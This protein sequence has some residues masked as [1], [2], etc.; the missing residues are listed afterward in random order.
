MNKSDS[1]KIFAQFLD[2]VQEVPEKIALITDQSQMSYRDISNL[3]RVI[4]IQLSQYNIKKGQTIVLA[5]KR[6]E[7]VFAF[8]IVSS[9]RNFTLVFASDREIKNGGLEFDRIVG[10][11]ESPCFSVASQIIIEPAWFDLMGSIPEWNWDGNE[12]GSCAFVTTTSGS[13]GRPKFVYLSEEAILKDI[14]EIRWDSGSELRSMRHVSTSQ[15]T[16]G[17]SLRTNLRVLLAGG[18]VIA[19]CESLQTAIQMAELWRASNMTT[20]PGAMQATLSQNKSEQYLSNLRKIVL[21]GAYA[22]TELLQKLSEKTPAEVF[23]SYGASE[24]GPLIIDRFD[25]ESPSQAGHMGRIDRSDID[26]VFC[27]EDGKIDR[28][29]S[30]GELVIKFKEPYERKYLG[31]SVEETYLQKDLFRSGDILRR[32]GDVF[33][34]LGR[35]KN[36]LNQNGNKYSLESIEQTLKSVF[37]NTEFVALAVKDQQGFEQLGLTYSGRTELSHASVQHIL[38]QKWSAMT[39]GRLLRLQGIPMTANGKV[40]RKKIENNLTSQ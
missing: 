16:A 2:V 6:A 8:L 33:Y 7:F 30:K 22:P 26:A 21:M 5:S 4:D 27:D 37:P 29:L 40:D 36:V 15:T 11:E 38:K 9:F 34:Y 25:R 24:T 12:E 35:K 39:L 17:V 14:A 32:N 1:Q 18:S 19:T 13:T 28:D 31:S 10:T 20:T 23:T 3:A